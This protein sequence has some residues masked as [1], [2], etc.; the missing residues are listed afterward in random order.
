MKTHRQKDTAQPRITVIC[1][2]YTSSGNLEAS[3]GFACLIALD[4]KNILF[5]T[6]SDG[7]VLSRNMARL[8]IDPTSIDLLMISHQHWDHVGGIYAIL[9]AR[10]DL[11]VCVGRSFSVHFQEDMKRYGAD[12]IEVDE[13]GEILPGLFTTGEME[14]MLPEQAALL[15]TQAGAVVITGCAHPG[16]VRIVEAAKKILPKDAIALVMGGFHLLH[17][18]DDEILNI[19]GKFKEM[20]VHYAAASHCSGERARKIFA[21]Q[22]AERFIA[23]GAGSIIGLEDLQP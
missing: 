7:G 19:I 23:L 2:N 8:G 6:G 3:W 16:I 13:A 4:G 12:I 18:G 5:D 11:R 14:G 21:R 20:D 15:Q 10:R 22:Y 9:S 17:D 1:D